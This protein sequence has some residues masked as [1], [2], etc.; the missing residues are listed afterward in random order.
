MCEININECESQ[1]CYNKGTCM[2]GVNEY[3]CGCATSFVGRNCELGELTMCG[4][5]FF[6]RFFLK[7]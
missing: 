3:I 1:P 4:S 6:A 7:I 5:M 2:D